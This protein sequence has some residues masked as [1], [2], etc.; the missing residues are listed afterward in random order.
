MSHA[1]HRFAV[2]GD[3]GAG[4]TTAV[5]GLCE[6][7]RADG[8][9]VAGVLQPARHQGPRRVGYDLLDP[10]D[11]ARYDLATRKTSFGPGELCYAFDEAGWGWGAERIARARRD[12]DVLVVDEMGKLEARGRGHLPALLRAEDGE[13][14]GVWVLSVRAVALDAVTAALGPFEHVARIDG[15]GG[16]LDGLRHRINGLLG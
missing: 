5:S 14:C 10:H 15:G 7:L 9:E 12:A 6:A 16:S 11:G 8:H 4:K 3:L 13:R 2:V 1:I